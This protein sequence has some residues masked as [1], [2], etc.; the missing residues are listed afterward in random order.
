MIDIGYEFIEGIFSGLFSTDSFFWFSSSYKFLAISVF[1]L[2]FYSNILS[3]RFDWGEAKLPFDKSKFINTII[4]VL[5][6]A[7]YD[8][9]LVL[10]DSLLSPIDAMINTYNP[11]DHALFKEEVDVKTEDLGVSAALIQLANGVISTIKNPLSIITSIAYGVFWILDNI[12]YSVFLIER[13]FFLTVLKILGPIAFIMSIHEKYRDLLYKWIK[14]Y[15][16]AY[17]LIIPFF[18]VI[19]ITNEMYLELYK[20]SDQI[21]LIDDLP[22]MKTFVYSII[23]GLSFWIKLRLFK[24]SSEYIYKLFT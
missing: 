17:L 9:V 8:K 4:V 5:I 24:K 12:I 1:M 13:F 18:L 2:S 21:P 19:Y 3:T 6:I 15:V 10:F 20:Q 14:L 11:L 7:S 23:V 22:F 16:S